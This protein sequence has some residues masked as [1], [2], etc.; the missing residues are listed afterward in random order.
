MKPA[1]TRCRWS[2]LEP[3]QWDLLLRLQSG[4]I[5]HEIKATTTIKAGD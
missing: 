1:V 3:G 2:C 4:E 5:L